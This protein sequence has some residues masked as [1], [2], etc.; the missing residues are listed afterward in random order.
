MDHEPDMEPITQYR[1][2]LA[3]K[4][5]E[6]ADARMQRIKDSL[7]EM[8]IALSRLP[9]INGLWGMIATVIGVSLTMI[10][11]VVGILIMPFS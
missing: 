8:K 4:R 3:D 5:F 9:T 2:D 10:A 11:L 7:T 6:A 1:L